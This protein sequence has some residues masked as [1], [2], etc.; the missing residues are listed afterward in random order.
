[1]IFCHV[2]LKT[3]SYVLKTIVCLKTLSYVYFVLLN[4]EDALRRLLC[5]LFGAYHSRL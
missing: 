4:F 3:R 1:M 2:C 5:L